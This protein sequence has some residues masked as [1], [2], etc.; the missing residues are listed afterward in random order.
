MTR[1]EMVTAVA[2]A[3]VHHQH[4]RDA[5]IFLAMLEAASANATVLDDRVDPLTA[6]VT[7]LETQMQ[8]L[9]QPGAAVGPQSDPPAK[10][11]KAKKGDE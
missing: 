1:D 8:N 5:E 2:A 4:K 11:A 10:P 9:N 6:R 3:M 7:A